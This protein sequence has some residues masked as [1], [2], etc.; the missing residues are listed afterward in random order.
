MQNQLRILYESAGYGVASMNTDGVGAQVTLLWDERCLPRCG[1]CGQ[2]MRIN[3]K[4]PQS[5]LD[6]RWGGEVCGDTLRSCAGLLPAL[7]RCSKPCGSRLESP[8]A[9]ASRARCSRSGWVPDLIFAIHPHSSFRFHVSRFRIPHARWAC[10]DPY[11]RLY[12]SLSAPA[13][14]ALLNSSYPQP[15]SRIVSFSPK[16]R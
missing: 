12:S 9:N 2:A 11:R 10:A 7:P 16:K 5:A 13:W 1:Q 14:I 4:T 15:K 3:R 6:L 8:A